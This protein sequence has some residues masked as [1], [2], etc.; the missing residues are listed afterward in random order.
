MKA[1]ATKEESMETL[2]V[3]QDVNTS[4]RVSDVG[5]SFGDRCANGIE[6]LIQEMG[7]ILIY[8]SVPCII[9]NHPRKRR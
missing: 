5:L 7:E 4:D 9:S 3:A 2:R 1:D 8:V 6:Y